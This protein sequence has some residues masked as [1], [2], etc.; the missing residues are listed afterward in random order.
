[1]T[2]AN[3]AEERTVDNISRKTG[4]GPEC[5]KAYAMIEPSWAPVKTKVI[6][7]LHRKPVEKKT[8]KNPKQKQKR[9]RFETLTQ[10]WKCN[11]VEERWCR[12]PHLLR[13]SRCNGTVEVLRILP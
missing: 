1:M 9:S 4:L 7:A 8:K 2:A 12:K 3:T 5:R 10:C 13:C 6:N 11:H